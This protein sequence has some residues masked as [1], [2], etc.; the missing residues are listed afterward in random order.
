MHK[1]ESDEFRFNPCTEFANRWA[2]LTAGNKL[3]NYNTMAI[4]WGEM[5]SL[6][7]HR[8]KNRYV[9][10][11]YVKPQRYTKLFM[12]NNE[13]FSVCFFS[14]EYRNDLGY[15]GSHSGKDEDKVAKTSLTPKE[16]DKAVYFNEADIVLKCRKIYAHEL[17]KE[18]FIDE[19]IRKDFY[20]LEDYHTMYI[21]EIEEVYIKD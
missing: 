9:V 1:I 7:G 10:T 12:D 8:V 4:S 17:K 15:L 13:Y 3:D 19:T 2:L 20:S 14:E 5:G 16:D 6:W 21:G 11:V 18:G